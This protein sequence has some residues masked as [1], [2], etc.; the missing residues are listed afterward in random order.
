MKTRTLIRLFIAAVLP[1]TSCDVDY[2]LGNSTAKSRVA[3]NALISPQE[4]FAVKLHWSGSYAANSETFRP[5]EQA[6]IRLLEE[7]VEAV[8]CT[9]SPDGETR[10]GFRATAGR[11]YRLEV[12]VPDYGT[13]TAETDI[14]AQPQA[15]IGVRYDKGSYRHFEMTALEYDAD[16]P[17]IWI[18]G[19]S[20]YRRYDYIYDENGFWTGEYDVTYDER[21]EPL[22][23]FYTTS[24]FVDQVNG[25]NDAYEA[26]DKEATVEFEEFLRLPRKDCAAALP[27]RFS[28]WGNKKVRFRIVAASAAYDRYTRSRYKQALNSQYNAE[29]NPFIEQVTVYTN[30]G[31]GLGIF[32]GLNTATCDLDIL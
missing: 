6:E 22:Y 31:N 10:T 8:R 19:S 3:V 14:P 28:V 18:Y 23:G 1:A 25:A 17:A 32:A 29:N 5:V 11:H 20:F 15:A 7:G 24:P 26:S 16:T 27:L 13:L 9:A 30:I 4:D 21:E 12:T 2:D